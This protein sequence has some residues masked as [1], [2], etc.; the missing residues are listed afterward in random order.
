MDDLKQLMTFT[1][2]PVPDFFKNLSKEEQREL[3]EY[4][5]HVVSTKNDGFEELYYTIGVVIK[6]IPNFVLVPL[7]LQYI[8]P[9]IAA[10]VCEKLKLDQAVG[11][12]ND[13]P[14]EYIGEIAMHT[15]SKRSAEILEKLRPSLAE[16]CIK[17]EGEHHPMKAL[18][19]GQFISPNLLK[20][21][22]KYLYL[23]ENID[24]SA[25]EIYKELIEKIRSYA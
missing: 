12:A 2:K 16:K 10:G 25:L 13:L 1:K 6:F 15:S 8:K 19:I 9:A 21:S 4:V 18:E 20:I 22:A 14:P 3:R 24:E 5:A 11:L 7:T 17:Y 23:L